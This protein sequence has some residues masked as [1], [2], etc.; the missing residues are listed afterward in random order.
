MSR[1]QHGSD[2]RFVAAREEAEPTPLAAPPQP[3]GTGVMRVQQNRY[4]NWVASGGTPEIY[5]PVVLPPRATE[6]TFPVPVAVNSDG[7][8]RPGPFT[9]RSGINP[10]VHLTKYTAAASPVVVIVGDSTS[11]PTPNPLTPLDVLWF[12][13]QRRMREDNPTKTHSF[14]NFAMG[15]SAMSTF[16]APQVLADGVLTI[17]TW[18]TNNTVAWW[19]YVQAVMPDLLFFNFGV[20]DSFNLNAVTLASALSIVNGWG[21][22]PPAWQAN[23]AYTRN[24]VI[25]DSNG[26][27]QVMAANSGTS[28]ASPPTW[29]TSLHSPTVDNTATWLVMSA[30]TYTA[31]KPDIVLI[32]NKSA[33]PSAGGNF[34]ATKYQIGRL[35]AASLQRTAALSGY[36][37]GV[38][39]LPRLGL[40]DIGRVFQQA[41]NGIDPGEQVMSQSITAPVT[42]TTFPYILPQTDGDLDMTWTIPGSNQTV[43]TCTFYLAAADGSTT[44]QQYTNYINIGTSTGT[45]IFANYFPALGSPAMPGA[46]QGFGWVSTGNNT[47]QI[48]LRGTH[49]YVLVNGFVLYNAL[50]PRYRSPCTPSMNILSPPG[51]FSPIL[52]SYNLSTMQKTT[53]SLTATETY[54]SLNGPTGGNGINHDASAAIAGIDARVLDATQFA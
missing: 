41:V 34:S 3:M 19:T 4:D 18:Y 5:G 48:T 28:G 42:V 37:F 50:V 52:V 12:Q 47:V 27:M 6:L 46:N 44:S 33:N 21:T 26:R 25:L 39:G 22:V 49:L 23:T 40:I 2:G 45:N 7:Y 31:K 36:N 24:A 15:G 13:L 11:T 51:G 43:L 30:G 10:A 20:N 32:T 53:P 9:S 14:Q 54:G 38:S 1:A 16:I 17:P 35:A 8:A 29:Q